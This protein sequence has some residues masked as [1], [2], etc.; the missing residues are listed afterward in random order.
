MKDSEQSQWE[1]KGFHALENRRA[2]FPSVRNWTEANTKRE[3]HTSRFDQFFSE[4]AAMAFRP[5]VTFKVR[6]PMTSQA[7]DT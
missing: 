7:G 3:S 6:K 4:R 1:Q 5:R 2:L